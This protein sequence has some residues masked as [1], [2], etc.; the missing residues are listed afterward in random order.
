MAK[1]RLAF[2]LILAGVTAG[3][4]AQSNE[5]IDSIL[6]EQTATLGSAAY[7]ALS[8]VGLVADEASPA[9]AVAAAVDEGWLAEGTDGAAPATFGQV[10][11]LLMAAHGVNGGLMYRFFPGP[12]YAA[13]EFVA[14]GWSPERRAPGDPVSGEFL[15]RVTGNFLE[16]T[17]VSR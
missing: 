10:A 12:R 7:I 1:H 15:L 4:A 9:Q 2:L 8:G 11:R 17:G 14:R 16:M 13:R 5:R 6:A 3:I